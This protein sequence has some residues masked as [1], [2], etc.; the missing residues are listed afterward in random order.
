MGAAGEP[1]GGL[2]IGLPC[3]PA[4][5]PGATSG[6][7]GLGDGRSPWLGRPGRSDVCSLQDPCQTRVLGYGPGLAILQKR[8]QK[9]IRLSV[10]YTFQPI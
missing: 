5:S 9:T 10:R 8:C 7:D 3:H 6:I 1:A 2:P 4:L